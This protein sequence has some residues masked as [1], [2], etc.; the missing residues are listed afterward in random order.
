MNP[1]KVGARV[2]V[3]ANTCDHNYTVGSVCTVV[4][5]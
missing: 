3:V 4:L 5:V 2:R 1:V